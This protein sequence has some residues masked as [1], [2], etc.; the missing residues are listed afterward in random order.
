MT[1][2]DVTLVLADYLAG[3]LGVAE[4]RAVEAGLAACD[5][6]RRYLRGYEL[7]I[8]LARDAYPGA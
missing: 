5:R 1:C 7:T 2:R 4:R 8:A 3:D 6:C